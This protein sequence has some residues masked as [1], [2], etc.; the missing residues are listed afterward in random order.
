MLGLLYSRP[1]Y[2]KRQITGNSNNEAGLRAFER[3]SQHSPELG[4]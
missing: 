2:E 4:Q 1:D 3:P